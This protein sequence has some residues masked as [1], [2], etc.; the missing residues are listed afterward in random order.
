MIRKRWKDDSATL[1]MELRSLL[2]TITDF[3]AAGTET[4]VKN[5]IEEKGYNIGAIM[6]TFRLV[7]VGA[8]RGPHMFDIISWIGKEETLK[9]LDK[10]LSVIGK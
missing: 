7:I 2:E 5:W 1:L 9:R 6:N 4:I 10:G 3:S 8:S